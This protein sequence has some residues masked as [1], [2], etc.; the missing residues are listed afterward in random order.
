MTTTT[1]T[2]KPLSIRNPSFLEGKRLPAATPTKSPK[3]IVFRKIAILGGRGVGKSSIT[4]YCIYGEQFGANEPNPSIE[5]T[6]H[7]DFALTKYPKATFN[8]CIVDT[9]GYYGTGPANI[10]RNASIGVDCYVLVFSIASRSSFE[11]IIE[12]NKSLFD[13]LGNPPSIP[14]VLVGNMVDKNER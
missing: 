12:I 7:I 8:C 11:Q 10:T 6:H 4:H 14:R 2:L 9:P 5:Y 1:T 13:A 3:R